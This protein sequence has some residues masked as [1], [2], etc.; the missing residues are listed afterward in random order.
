[1]GRPRLG[2]DVVDALPLRHLRGDGQQ[3]ATRHG[4][5]KLVPA[6]IEPDR[7]S[8]E[9]TMSRWQF[10]ILLA[11]CSTK[12]MDRF[13]PFQIPSTKIDVE[14]VQRQRDRRRVETE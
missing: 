4:A 7:G 9:S 2:S 11:A 5:P 1:L 8:T 12:P 14:I 6:I 13:C 3:R 10:F